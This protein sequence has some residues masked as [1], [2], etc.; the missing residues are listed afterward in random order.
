[1]ASQ[2]S[3]KDPQVARQ[4]L[5]NVQAIDQDYFRAMQDAGT[6]LEQAGEFME[7]TMVDEFVNA[8]TQVLNAAQTTFDAIDKIAETVNTVLDTVKNFSEALTSGITGV[9]KAIF[10]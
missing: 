2:V 8:G 6:S 9:A 4:W 1:M 7:G 3:I 10:G 5:Q